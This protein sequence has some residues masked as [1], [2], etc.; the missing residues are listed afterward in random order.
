MHYTRSLSIF[1]RNSS[2]DEIVNVN[3]FYDDI[4]LVHAEASA[5]AH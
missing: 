1:T 2:G 4:V 5:Y 3:I